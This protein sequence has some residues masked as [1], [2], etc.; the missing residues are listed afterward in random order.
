MLPYMAY[1]DPMGW[2]YTEKYEYC[3]MLNMK[4]NVKPDLFCVFFSDIEMV[5]NSTTVQWLWIQGWHSFD[6]WI[7]YKPSASSRCHGHLS[8]SERCMFERKCRQTLPF[9]S[10]DTEVT[11]ESKENPWRSILEWTMKPR[12]K[13][14]KFTNIFPSTSVTEAT[15]ALDNE[16]E[17]M[18]QEL[19]GLGQTCKSI[20]ITTF[21]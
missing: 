15:S 19:V 3:W 4:L 13:S 20:N 6:Q 17:R 9:G 21:S 14:W 8:K 11:E 7:H 12:E 2:G 18:V 5:P 1:M 10:V 16:S